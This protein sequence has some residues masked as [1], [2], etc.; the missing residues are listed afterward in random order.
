L[1]SKEYRASV[2]DGDT[3]INLEKLELK[4]G[5]ADKVVMYVCRR[6]AKFA[7]EQYDRQP[8]VKESFQ[9]IIAEHADDWNDEVKVAGLWVQTSDVYDVESDEDIRARLIQLE[10]AFWES[11]RNNVSIEEIREQLDYTPKSLRYFDKLIS[12]LWD[13]GGPSQKSFEKVVA[14]FG[15]YVARVIEKEYVGY[16]FVDDNR[17]WNYQ[18]EKT[19][20][21]PNIRV[22]PFAWMHKRLKNGDLLMEKYQNMIDFMKGIRR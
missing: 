17:V 16:W 8:R 11:F 15:A 7:P 22:A 6:V 18:F 10:K 13:G 14:A 12:K 5:S 3:D 2:I 9:R 20:T 19:D 4:P 1:F 21:V